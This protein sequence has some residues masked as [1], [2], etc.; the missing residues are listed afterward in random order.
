MKTLLTGILLFTTIFGYSQTKLIY[1]ASGDALEKGIKAHDKENYKSA[2]KYFNKIQEG[3]TNYHTGQYEIAT[4]YFAME[5]YQKSIDI[6]KVEMEIENYNS[7]EFYNLMGNAYDELE[8]RE[9]AIKTYT[10]GISIYPTY[11]RL[12]YNRAITYE[13]MEEWQKS[14]NDLMMS[15]RLNPYHYNSHYKLAELAKEEGEY[16]KAMLCYNSFL[17]IKASG[18]LEFLSQYEDY[19]IDEYDSEPRGLELS[20]EDYSDIDEIIVSKA[21]MDKKYKTPNKLSLPI[22][23]QNYLLFQ[24]L[25]KRELGEESCPDISPSSYSSIPDETPLM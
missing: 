22:V 10:K 18:N 5:E 21:A 1:M 20:T 16:T 14:A 17:L 15:V 23:K 9:N 7:T 11:Y 13:R 4:T 2:L 6:C 3:D 12:Y 19:L 25:Q 24:E 8:D